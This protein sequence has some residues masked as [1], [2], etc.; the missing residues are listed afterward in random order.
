MNEDLSDNVRMIHYE[1]NTVK[2]CLVSKYLR[3]GFSDVGSGFVLDLGSTIFL[4]ERQR[5]SPR[6]PQTL[7]ESSAQA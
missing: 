5:P 3:F 7:T 6:A 1:Y 4:P 2:P